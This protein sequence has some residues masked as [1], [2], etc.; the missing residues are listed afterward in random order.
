MRP[1]N[2][3]S[4]LGALDAEPVGITMLTSTGRLRGNTYIITV[5]IGYFVFDTCSAEDAM[6]M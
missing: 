4:P 1:A 6:R 2:P 5:L 3:P